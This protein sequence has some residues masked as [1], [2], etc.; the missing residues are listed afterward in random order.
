MLENP[1]ISLIALCVLSELI[2]TFPYAGSGFQNMRQQFVSFIHLS[3]VNF[4]LQ[5]TPQTKI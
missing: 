4:T 5:P 2:S 1:I 3:F